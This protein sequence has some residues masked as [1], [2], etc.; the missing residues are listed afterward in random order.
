VLVNGAWL[1]LLAFSLGFLG[2]LNDY[3]SPLLV[4]HHKVP[5]GFVDKDLMAS[6]AFWPK[7]AVDH[8]I[9]MG[10]HYVVHLNEMVHSNFLELMISLLQII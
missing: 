1:H 3:F 8:F 5:T 2:S 9:Q 7:V 6:L 4:S 10:L